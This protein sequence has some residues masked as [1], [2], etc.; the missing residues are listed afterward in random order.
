[1]LECPTLTP[2][3]AWEAAEKPGGEKG[4]Q[5]V[6]KQHRLARDNRL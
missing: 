5:N 1:M 3:Q 6:R 4:I 2:R